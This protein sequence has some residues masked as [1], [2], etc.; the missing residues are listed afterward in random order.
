LS[1]LV[2]RGA[3]EGEAGFAPRGDS[4]PCAGGDG[5]G[6]ERGGVSSAGQPEL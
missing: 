5:S 4:V 6:G 2:W 1:L 3:L